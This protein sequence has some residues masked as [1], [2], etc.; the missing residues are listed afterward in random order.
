MIFQY[1][2]IILISEIF[3]AET[4]TDIILSNFGSSNANF[5]N[6]FHYAINACKIKERATDQIVENLLDKFLPETKIEKC[7][8]ACWFE[9][10]QVVSFCNIV[11][12]A[13]IKF[14]F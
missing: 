9:R 5:E 13:L 1:T 14:I 3:C 12:I 11:K 4:E 10:F 6:T 8:V 7:F 2:F